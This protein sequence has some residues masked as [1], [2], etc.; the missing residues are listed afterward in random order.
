MP[1]WSVRSAHV[2]E[3]V[4]KATWTGNSSRDLGD[5]AAVVE[6]GVA[7]GTGFVGSVNLLAVV[8]GQKGVD[9]PSLLVQ[10]FAANEGG[11]GGSVCGGRDIRS[12]EV[13]ECRLGC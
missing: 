7:G 5:L 1:N 12:V 11:E 2:A 9:G 4:H 3:R 13:A 6:R 8:V 10:R